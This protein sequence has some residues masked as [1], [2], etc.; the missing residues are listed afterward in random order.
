VESDIDAEVNF[1]VALSVA[2]LFGSVRGDTGT[3][4]SGVEIT[5]SKGQELFRAQT[6]AEGRFR[7]EGLSSGEYQVKLDRDSIPPGYSV[8]ELE[9]Q[10]TIVDPSASGQCAFI[11]RAIRNI[12]GRV[13]IYDRRSQ[14]EISVPHVMV[15]LRELSRESVTDEDG[16]YLFRDL[17]AGSYTLTVLYE[18]EESRKEVMLPDGP[19]FPKGIDINLVA[20]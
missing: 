13:T 19:V 10:R 5:V 7:V 4:L 17:P 6:D 15:L 20:K 14:S 12:S 18:G 9:T 8:K 2:R 3:G 1:G 11:L 16:I